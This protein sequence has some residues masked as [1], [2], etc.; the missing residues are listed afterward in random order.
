MSKVILGKEYND[1]VTGFTGIAICRYTYL[2]GCD[3]ISLQPKVG[4]TGA[5]PAT[6]SFDEP[7]LVLVSEGIVS[8]LQPAAVRRATGGPAKCPDNRRV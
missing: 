7:S 4:D 5:I 8:S 6:E 1:F 3:R 2:H